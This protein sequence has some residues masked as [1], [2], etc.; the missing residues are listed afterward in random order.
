MKRRVAGLSAAGFLLTSAANRGSS[1][2]AGANPNFARGADTDPSGL[3]EGGVT[4][5]DLWLVSSVRYHSSRPLTQQVV[6]AGRS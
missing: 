4:G 2:A 1:L 5:A 6:K 3:C